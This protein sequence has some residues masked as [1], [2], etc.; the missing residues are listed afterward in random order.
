MN[1]PHFPT[2]LEPGQRVAARPWL[3]LP[4]PGAFAVNTLAPYFC[5][6]TVE[7]TLVDLAEIAFDQPQFEVWPRRQMVASVDLHPWPHHCR[8]CRATAAPLD[9]ATDI[10]AW[11]RRCAAVEA[12]RDALRAE[13]FATRAALT[14]PA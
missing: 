10:A 4:A 5:P 14:G 12:E 3:W 13:L 7:S 8:Q 9:A 2:S 11:R 6:A 1:H